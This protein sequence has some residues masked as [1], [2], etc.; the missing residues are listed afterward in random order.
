[1]LSHT[2]RTTHTSK[3]CQGHT[4]VSLLPH[5]LFYRQG[6]RGW[7]P[8]PALGVTE[9]GRGKQLGPQS[10]LQGQC[11]YFGERHWVCALAVLCTFYILFAFDLHLP[12]GSIG[13]AGA[14]GLQF[15]Q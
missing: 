4:L 3:S 2:C 9:G 14:T 1:M 15:Y 6:N 5:K 11:P 12:V 7:A 13:P 8:L 10:W